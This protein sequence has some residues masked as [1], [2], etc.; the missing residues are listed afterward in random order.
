MSYKFNA[1]SIKISM[2]FFTEL[3]KPKI[4]KESQKIQ[5]SQINVEKDEQSDITL[6]DIKI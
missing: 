1:I 6:H 5:N 3:D 4:H 2:V